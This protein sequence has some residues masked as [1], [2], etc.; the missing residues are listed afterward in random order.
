MG[1][2]ILVVFHAHPT[3]SGKNDP[4]K[5]DK[6]NNMLLISFKIQSIIELHQNSINHTVTHH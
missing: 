1:T 3:F 5:N 6:Y 4:P 2:F